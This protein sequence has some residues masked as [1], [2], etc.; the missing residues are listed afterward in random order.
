MGGNQRCISDG[1]AKWFKERGEE[2]KR[3]KIKDSA[4]MRRRTC[5][6]D[7]AQRKGIGLRQSRGGMAHISQSDLCLSRA[8]TER[9]DDYWLIMAHF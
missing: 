6:E 7:N 4:G 2:G 8:T 5:T 3:A 9:P 1:K